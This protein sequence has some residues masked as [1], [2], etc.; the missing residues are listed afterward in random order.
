[1]ECRCGASGDRLGDA[2]T[3]CAEQLSRLHFICVSHSCDPPALL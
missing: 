2:L 3:G 1:M